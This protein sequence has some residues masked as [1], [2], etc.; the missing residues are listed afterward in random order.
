VEEK[1]KLL[2]DGVLPTE[3]AKD[4]DTSA[5]QM[6][7]VVTK[8]VGSI[9]KKANA[10]EKRSA[11]KFQRKLSK[12]TKPKQRTLNE[13]EN[14][15]ERLLLKEALIL[16]SEEFVDRMRDHFGNIHELEAEE[17]E[18]GASTKSEKIDLSN[19]IDAI[20]EDDYFQDR[21]QEV[22]RES[23]DGEPETFENLLLRLMNDFKKPQISWLQFLGHFSKRGR[24]QGYNEIE[25]SPSKEK[26]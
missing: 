24:L 1:V 26:I 12:V 16:V 9:N 17:E 13:L 15:V 19:F 14:E 5:M 22:V 25:I 18:E 4:I 7:D 11:E 8:T 23:L 3:E 10:R 6:F 21:M 20:A 2:E